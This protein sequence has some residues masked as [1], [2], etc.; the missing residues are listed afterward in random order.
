MKACIGSIVKRIWLAA[1]LNS[2]YCLNT[3]DYHLG[4]H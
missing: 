2:L 3:T 4:F 1:F